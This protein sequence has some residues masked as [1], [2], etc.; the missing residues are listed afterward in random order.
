MNVAE[1]SP[2]GG[3]CNEHVNDSEGSPQAAGPNAP[4][5]RG[6][7]WYMSNPWGDIFGQASR[8]GGHYTV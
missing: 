7:L 3:I 1:E 6:S 8:S 2:W 4:R 5:K